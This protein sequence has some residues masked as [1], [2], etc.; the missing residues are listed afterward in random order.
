MEYLRSQMVYQTLLY[1]DST[2]MTVINYVKKN[3]E[4]NDKVNQLNI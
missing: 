3:I 1:E 4:N 2:V